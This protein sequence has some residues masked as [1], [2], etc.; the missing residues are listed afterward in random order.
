MDARNIFC[1]NTTNPSNSIGPFW[2]IFNHLLKNSYFLPLTS[3]FTYLTFCKYTIH[4]SLFTFFN[5]ET[6]I[7]QKSV[8]Q[9]CI[10]IFFFLSLPSYGG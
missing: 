8:M 3:Y 2:S 9:I 4:F 1:K 5:S 6:Y 7:I 10:I